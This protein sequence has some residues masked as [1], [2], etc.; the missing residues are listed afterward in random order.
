MKHSNRNTSAPRINTKQTNGQMELVHIK[1]C[2]TENSAGLERG[3]A[4][5][6]TCGWVGTQLLLLIYEKFEQFLGVFIFSRYF[7][8][9]LFFIFFPYNPT[10]VT[11]FFVL[12]DQMFDGIIDSCSSNGTNR[13]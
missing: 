3:G 13:E 5:W 7:S 10:T 9:V 1:N 11:D 12:G 2:Q 4:L 8:T 6:G